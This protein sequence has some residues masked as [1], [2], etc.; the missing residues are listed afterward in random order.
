[1]TNSDADFLWWIHERMLSDHHAVGIGAKFM[2]RLRNVAERVR[3]YEDMMD[4]IKNATKAREA[5]KTWGEA[6]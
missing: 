1:M 6:G 2:I 5:D 4:G 3:D